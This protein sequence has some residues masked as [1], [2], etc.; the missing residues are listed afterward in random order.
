MRPLSHSYIPAQCQ[1]Q[2]GGWRRG[3]ARCR[4]LRP[5]TGGAHPRQACNSERT[6]N[7]CGP[8]QL[9]CIQAALPHINGWYYHNE[10][11]GFRCRGF[12]QMLLDIPL[13]V[14]TQWSSTA[15]TSQRA[16]NVQ[17]CGPWC[18]FPYIRGSIQASRLFGSTVRHLTCW[19]PSL[20]LTLNNI[21]SVCNNYI[22]VFIKIKWWS[23]QIM[24]HN[25]LFLPYH[26]I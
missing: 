9:A 22:N 2:G 1:S 17:V 6:S 26:S 8:S 3:S 7:R 13:S 20:H 5:Q 4:Y 16:Y 21:C 25:L 12:W 18:S 15:E 23:S 24:Q 10:R 11:I 14:S 19:A